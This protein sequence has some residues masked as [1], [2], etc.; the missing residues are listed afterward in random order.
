MTTLRSLERGGERAQERIRLQE[1]LRRFSFVK[2]V[3]ESDANFFLVQASFVFKW[4]FDRPPVQRTAGVA[5]LVWR[6]RVFLY[7]YSQV[8]LHTHHLH[9]LFRRC[10]GW[11]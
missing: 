9:P 2:E 7:K 1:A 3:K 6:A 10:K 5:G 4:V 8:V 11:Y